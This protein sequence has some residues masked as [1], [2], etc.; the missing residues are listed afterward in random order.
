MTNSN[1]YLVVGGDSLVGGGLFRAL[2]RRGDSALA[3][4]R[5]RNSLDARRVYLDFESGTEF[6]V[7]AGI[8]YAFVVA[9]ATNYERCETDPLAYQINV[10]L[11]PR[12]VISLLEQG[13]FVTFISTNSV[14]GGERPWPREDDPHAP[15]IAYARQKHSAEEVI[16]AACRGTKHE[17]HFN[18][19]RLTKIMGR[20]TS[21]L[22]N[23]FSAWEKGEPVQPFSDLIFAPMSVRFVG[24]AL[25]TIGPKRIAGNLHLSGAENVSYVDFAACLARK[26]GVDSSLIV[27][28]TAEE[29]G[30]VIPFKP[31]YSGLGMQRTTELT[32]VAPQTLDQVVSDLTTQSVQ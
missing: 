15:G 2:E 12:F 28:T 21:P 24:E 8:D 29:K 1:G 30:V 6:R 17:E 10:E 20:D 32:G 22:P 18:I 27:P 14:F 5:R 25:A 16:R 23:W 13:V 7:P 31:R 19:V 4:T 11:I 9:A 3:T 26:L